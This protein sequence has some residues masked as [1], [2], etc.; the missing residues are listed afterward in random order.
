[1]AVINRIP[2][3]Q[4]HPHPDNPRQDVGD[5]SE[6]ADSIKAKGILQ[7]LTVVRGRRGTAEEMAEIRARYAEL[8]DDER[9]GLNEKIQ[10]QLDNN[11]LAEGYTVVIGHRRLAAAK[12]AGLEDLPCVIVE[13]N[14]REQMQT[15]LIEN[16]QRS[17]L[18]K[19]EE[20]HGFQMMLDL[21]TPVEEIAEKTGFSETT[22]R[23]RLKWMELDQAKFKKVTEERQISLGDLDRLS[24]IENLKLR[25]ECLDKIGTSEF[26]MAVQKAV[27]RQSVEENMPKVKEWLKKV[28]AHKIGNSDRWNGKYERYGSTIY[29]DRW[30]E[31]GNL[32]KEGIA[33]E[34][35][36][37]WLGSDAFDYNQLELYHERKKAP[38]VKRSPEEIAREK[39]VKAAWDSLE[40]L[41]KSAHELRKQFIAEFN[42]TKKNELKVTFGAMIAGCFESISYNS[43]DRTTLYKLAGIED[44][45]YIPDRE[46]R[47]WNGFDK[48]PWADWAKFVY[49]MFGDEAVFCSRGYRGNFPAYEKNRKLELIYRWLDMLGYE[50]SSEETELLTGKHEAYKAGD[51]DAEM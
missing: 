40:S 1:M 4:L 22:V 10:E 6:L 17:D 18:T 20:A 15:M 45:G 49:A 47:F 2:I 36:F 24:Q 34:P 42:V 7:N 23:R 14:P 16:M 43:P 41:A 27:K 38:P 21:G 51:P 29:M 39:A 26:D 35:V 48:I 44:T 50:M 37:Y 11:W 31:E 12:L 33:D 8:S 25:N 3:D 30:G 5:V 13:M 28:K 46:D 19:F 32:P 9:A